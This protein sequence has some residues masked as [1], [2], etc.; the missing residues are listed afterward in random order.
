MVPRVAELPRL[1]AQ[2]RDRR[3]GLDDLLQDDVLVVR[4]AHVQLRV[5]VEPP[6]QA[7][8]LVVARREELLDD[9]LLRRT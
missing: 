7:A 8:Q 3:I 4:D 1:L 6:Q 9:R 5:A 2:L